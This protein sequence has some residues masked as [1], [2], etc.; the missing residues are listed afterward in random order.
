MVRLKQS[1][2]IAASRSHLPGGDRM[3]NVPDQTRTRLIRREMRV[4]A[5]LSFVPSARTAGSPLG[6]WELQMI[7]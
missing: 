1:R 4:R 3:R 2:K 5:R 6:K 7:L